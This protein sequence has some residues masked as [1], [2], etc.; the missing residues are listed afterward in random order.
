MAFFRIIT[1][2]GLIFL[3]VLGLCLPFIATYLKAQ[4]AYNEGSYYVKEDEPVVGFLAYDTLNPDVL[5]YKAQA[6]GKAKKIE[7]SRLQGFSWGDEQYL[8]L[9]QVPVYVGKGSYRWLKKAIVRRVPTLQAYLFEVFYKETEPFTGQ[10]SHF[11]SYVL[12]KSADSPE[13]SLAIPQY[14][15]LKSSHLE[16]IKSFLLDFFEEASPNFKEELQKIRK[17]GEL[18]NLP[19]W[20]DREAETFRPAE[21]TIPKIPS[22]PEN[23]EK[24]EMA[25]PTEVLEMEIDEIPKTLR[26]VAGNGSFIYFKGRL[27]LQSK[28][29]TGLF[30]DPLSKT[31][32]VN[33]PK[34][35]FSPDDTF[36]FISKCTLE[37]KQKGDAG[38]LLIWMDANVWARAGIECTSEGNLLIN[39]TLNRGYSDR[40]QHILGA[41][42][43]VYLRLSRY[44]EE[45]YAFYYSKDGKAWQLLRYFY[46]PSGPPKNTGSLGF[47]AASPFGKALKVFW[48]EIQY[49][50]EAPEGL[51]ND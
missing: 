36:D 15:D 29:Y 22:P 49:R 11:R 7:K 33:A 19:N 8:V 6:Q 31:S 50:A 44:G 30:K 46:L 5:L 45:A 9:D 3:G 32:Q 24:T 27:E 1:P 21:Q 12:R 25:F 43:S 41:A 48:E 23:L 2:Q 14:M 10:V 17:S 16:E 51:G 34:A 47:F 42:S 18:L 28:D 35:V 4:E 40:S 26:C 37:G 13:G 20:L 39:T 38:G